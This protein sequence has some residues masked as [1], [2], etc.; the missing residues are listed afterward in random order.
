[1]STANVASQALLR[2]PGPAPHL[3]RFLCVP[4]ASSG[5]RPKS[6]VLVPAVGG[7]DVRSR[8][9]EL[10][11]SIKGFLSEDHVGGG[12]LGLELFHGPVR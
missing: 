10:V 7:V 2:T 9:D 1:M 6:R 3:G 8:R 5:C 12:E 11:D 4:S